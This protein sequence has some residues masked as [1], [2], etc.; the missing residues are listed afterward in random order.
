MYMFQLYMRLM[1]CGKSLLVSFNL[2][3]VS[4]QQ[5]VHGAVSYW[6]AQIVTE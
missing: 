5:F 1:V 4:L 3:L 2:D 6:S